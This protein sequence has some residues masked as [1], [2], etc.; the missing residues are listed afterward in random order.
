M[1]YLGREAK[2]NNNHD[3][4]DWDVMRGTWLYAVADGRVLK[5]RFYDT[6]FTGSDS[7]KQGEIYIEHTVERKPST[8]NE[9]FVSGYFHLRKLLVSDGQWVKKGQ[10]IGKSGN[11]GESYAP[12]LHLSI[13]R[14][15][16]T[17]SARQAS[18]TI[19]A[20]GNS[21]WPLTID[22]YG[23]DAPKGFDPWSWAAYPAGALS[24]RLWDPE[25]TPTLDLE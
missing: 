12:H 8:Y 6:G 24:I 3:S 17:A 19:D 10:L 21:G 9:V 18:L 15:T 25:Y 20:S 7:P 22:P 5:A 16:N 14:L 13:F 11:N 4:H 1:D 2:F 23:F